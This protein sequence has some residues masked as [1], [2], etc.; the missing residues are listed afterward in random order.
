MLMLTRGHIIGLLIGSHK[1]VCEEVVDESGEVLTT[2]CGLVET[3][4]ND[5]GT[6]Y[7]YVLDNINEDAGTRY[8]YMQGNAYWYEDFPNLDLDILGE[9]V[10]LPE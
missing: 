9:G 10:D 7:Q 6:G 2:V 1:D 3:E 5:E 4:E 8:N